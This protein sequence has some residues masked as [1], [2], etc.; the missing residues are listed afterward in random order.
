MKYAVAFT[1]ACGDLQIKF[2]KAN[3]W[4]KAV[5]KAAPHLT[6]LDSDDLLLAKKKA[7]KQGQAFTV[8]EIGKKKRDSQCYCCICES[9][10]RAR[11]FRD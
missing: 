9:E 8:V 2:V 4:R 5:A 1:D 10:R 11:K 6:W 3:G 7:L